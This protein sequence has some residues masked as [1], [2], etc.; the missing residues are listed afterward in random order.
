MARAYTGA[1]QS[2]RNRLDELVS[3]LEEL[4]ANGEDPTEYM[5]RNRERL[6]RNI[7]DYER[8]LKR[9]SK[10][11]VGITSTAQRDG[12]RI[13]IRAIPSLVEAVS[14]KA[15]TGAEFP[16][17]GINPARIESLVGLASDGSPLQALFDEIGTG[18]SEELRDAYLNGAAQGLNP[19]AV[20][21]LMRSVVSDMGRYRAET[22]ARTEMHRASREA[23]RRAYHDSS[24]VKGY[25]RMCAQDSRVCLACL[26]LT[27]TRYSTA[28]IMPSHPNCRCVMLP[29]LVSWAEI[30]GDPTLE[31]EPPLPI[32]PDDIMRGL[33]EPEIRHIFGPARYEQWK[34][35]AELREFITVGNHPKW[36]PTLGIRPLS[37]PVQ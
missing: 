29:D 11:G 30:T 13:A 19:L 26:A 9:W 10:E 12:M 32:G 14:A 16:A 8:E 18:L 33:T 31:E 7:D 4:E 28:E 27:G 5:I 21:Q 3:T 15:P 34:E 2:T 37:E 25:T 20:A 36:G 17:V 1:V 24:V 35:G 6:L 23:H 22:I